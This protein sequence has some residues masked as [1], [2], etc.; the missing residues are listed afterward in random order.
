MSRARH[1]VF[2]IIRDFAMAH[3]NAD[4]F[5][6]IFS[7]E[8]VEELLEKIDKVREVPDEPTEEEKE[9]DLRRMVFANL[10]TI[11]PVMAGAIYSR[12]L[13]GIEDAL[14]K[15]AEANTVRAIIECERVLAGLPDASTGNL[16]C[17][18]LE[19]MRELWKSFSPDDEENGGKE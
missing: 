18:C 13:R 12:Y 5:D 9:K 10:D 6:S 4:Q 1:E 3:S 14:K 19:R 7:Q 16:L 17:Q 2:G 15:N 8:E 11:M